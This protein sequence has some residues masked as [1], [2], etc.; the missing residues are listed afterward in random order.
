M[1]VYCITYHPCN[2]L[3]PFNGGDTRFRAKSIS[4]SPK[5]TNIILGKPLEVNTSAAVQS[6]SDTN[7]FIF[8][9][10]VICVNWES[11]QKII[12]R[13]SEST[14]DNIHT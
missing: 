11:Q 10:I 1:N 8:V 3:S 14:R 2:Y 4:Y 7:T 13:F 9:L 5:S 12:E 6:L